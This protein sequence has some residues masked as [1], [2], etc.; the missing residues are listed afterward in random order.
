MFSPGLLEK[1]VHDS[2]LSLRLPC[3]K[4]EELQLKSPNV[5][6]ESVDNITVFKVNL[7]PSVSKRGLWGGVG[8]C[9]CRCE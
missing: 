8:G 6:N 9:M 5:L 2:K 1:T 3:H 7:E 4:A